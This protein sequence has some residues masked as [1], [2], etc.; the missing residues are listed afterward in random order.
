LDRDIGGRISRG[1]QADELTLKMAKNMQG[2]HARLTTGT[3]RKWPFSEEEARHA[4]FGL[5]RMPAP[6]SVELDQAG[7][8]LV[9]RLAADP[10][11][12]VRK[13]DA[14]RSTARRPGDSRPPRRR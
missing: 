8:E 11:E 5:V 4:E 3:P 7:H 9:R 1:P 10:V 14:H 6:H 12:L 13:S 2:A